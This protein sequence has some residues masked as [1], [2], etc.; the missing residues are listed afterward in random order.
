M[1]ELKKEYT[2]GE[3]TV[4]WKPSLCMHSEICVKTLPEVYK[5]KEKPWINLDNAATDAIVDQVKKCPSGALSFYFNA[6]GKPAEEETADV[7]LEIMK[8]GPML[9]HG[10]V[11]VKHN[12][13]REELKEKRSAYCRC[14][15]S[16]NKPFCDGNHKKI[17]FEG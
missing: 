15:A 11:R 10:T 1:A 9:V 2:N 8:N 4:V 5:P 14:G 12:D 7:S 6:D 3:V 16:A 13:G 17:N